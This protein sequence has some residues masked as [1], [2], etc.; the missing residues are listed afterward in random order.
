M[1]VAAKKLQDLE[2]SIE[3]FFLGKWIFEKDYPCIPAKH[4]YMPKLRSHDTKKINRNTENETPLVSSES[5]SSAVVKRGKRTDIVFDILTPDKSKGRSIKRNKKKAEKVSGNSETAYPRILSRKLSLESGIHFTKKTDVFEIVN[6]DG[7]LK[8]KGRG[9]K[10][11][12]N[13]SE[14][15]ESQ[16]E[17]TGTGLSTS[18]VPLRK[19]Q[20]V[21]NRENNERSAQHLERKLTKKACECLKDISNS[22]IKQTSK[23]E[24]GLE[25]TIRC[26][27]KEPNKDGH[28]ETGRSSR[29]FGKKV[30]DE[31]KKKSKY[32]P[33]YSECELEKN[34]TPIEK[35]NEP[36][37][38]G[39][40]KNLARKAKTKMG[41]YQ[42]FLEDG[43][44]DAHDETWVEPTVK[45]KKIAVKKLENDKRKQS[46]M[47][48]KNKTKT[49]R[50]QN[51]TSEQRKM[52][53]ENS[54][55]GADDNVN[56]RKTKVRI[57]KASTEE[58][59][60]AETADEVAATTYSRKKQKENLKPDDNVN[61][62]KTK[63]R[64]K[65]ASEKSKKAK[66]A[67]EVAATTYSQKKQK[68][69]LKP[70]GM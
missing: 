11:K 41:S 20:R 39:Q 28:G 18:A 58:S 17:T 55:Q 24:N 53:N 52:Q 3:S 45:K 42:C 30:E 38:D 67:D 4:L 54:K 10:R 1:V 59:K 6:P 37:K 50:S 22:T 65:K 13:K 31:P 8:D 7:Q 14:I 66:T 35:V 43:S 47:E 25:K 68:E 32:R 62:R 44:D 49:A 36:S 9:V 56:A 23:K 29:H 70:E 15:I 19:S 40:D 27:E 51:K 2:I 69:N 21:Q 48:D 63:V 16:A 5:P 64:T 60:K 57:K 26:K 61:A 34:D 46:M 12:I 33:R